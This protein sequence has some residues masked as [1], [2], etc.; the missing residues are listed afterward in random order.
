MITVIDLK[1][2]E[3][4]YTWWLTC[5]KDVLNYTCLLPYKISKN[6]DYSI[7]S[8][9]VLEEYIL[10]NFTIETIYYDKNKY[11]LDFFVRYIGETFFKNISNLKWSF[12]TDKEDFYYGVPVLIKNNSELFTKKSPLSFVIASLDRKTGTYIRNILKNNIE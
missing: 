8:L 7:D 10:E 4:A 9:E 5:M 12:V 3:E 11:A 1:N 2:K 6:L